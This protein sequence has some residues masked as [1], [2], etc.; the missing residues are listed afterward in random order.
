MDY[1]CGVCGCSLPMVDEDANMK[2]FHCGTASCQGLM[3]GSRE[4]QERY[5]ENCQAVEEKEEKIFIDYKFPLSEKV[6][7]GCADVYEIG[8]NG[9][10]L[11]AGTMTYSKDLDQWNDGEFP[12]DVSD[13]DPVKCAEQMI[14]Y[15][16][17]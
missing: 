12:G 15:R 7:G 17:E 4:E 3:E 5:G 11:Y 14:E 10:E 1:K 2:L 9:G 13:K 8:D 16:K 6:D